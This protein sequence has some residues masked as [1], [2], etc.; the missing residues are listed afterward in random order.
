MVLEY[1]SSWGR[2]SS[3]PAIPGLQAADPVALAPKG[4]AARSGLIA[5]P[6]ASTEPTPLPGAFLALLRGLPR[7]EVVSLT[8]S[9]AYRYSGL[10]VQGYAGALAIYVIPIEGTGS[11]AVLCYAAG[12]SPAELRPCERIVAG[13]TAVGRSPLRAEPQLPLRRGAVE[14]AR[15]PGAG[16]DHAA[17]GD[18]RTPEPRRGCPARR[19]AGQALR[20]RGGVTRGDRSARAASRAEAAL[21]G[22]LIGGEGRLQRPGER[23]RK[24]RCRGVRGRRYAGGRG[25]DG[26]QQGALQLRPARLQPRLGPARRKVR[27][28]VGGAARRVGGFSAPNS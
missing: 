28:R 14:P 1:P 26:R 11:T 22:A 16:A 23:R 21:A 3:P 20:R 2:A 5:W 18:T 6:V 25:R 10:S 8:N 9:Q 4:E 24:R 15:L 19:R 12:G 17:R 7:T 27:R 13:L